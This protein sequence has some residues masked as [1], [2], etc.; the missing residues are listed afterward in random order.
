MTWGKNRTFLSSDGGKHIQDEWVL[1]TPNG[2]IRAE[3]VVN[4]A[5]YRAAEWADVW[6]YVPRVSGASISDH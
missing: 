4:A 2:T 6:P 3:Y 1:T 5:G